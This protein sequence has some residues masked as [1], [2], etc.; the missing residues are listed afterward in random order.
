MAE[1]WKKYREYVV[2]VVFMAVFFGIVQF[3]IVTLFRRNLDMMNALQESIV[4]HKILEE[5]SRQIPSMKVQAETITAESAQLDV[6]LSEDDVVRLAESLETLGGTL[7][8][9]VSM[10]AAPDSVA[11]AFLAIEKKSTA[12]NEETSSEGEG[13]TS[14]KSGTKSEN[15]PHLLPALPFARTV[16]V[17]INATGKYPDIVR[18]LGKLDSTPTLLDIL[19]ISIAPHEDEESSDTLPNRPVVFSGAPTSNT[20]DVS[21]PT[22]SDSGEATVNT[23]RADMVEGS[24]L[25]AVYLNQP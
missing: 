23:P 2:I 24:F 11:A 25:A 14:S 6:L 3:G 7:G 10:E 19:S 9:S 17:T 1:F 22:L 20:V 21:T 8:V 12:K 13:N 5:E 15:V 16:F 18:F 4:D